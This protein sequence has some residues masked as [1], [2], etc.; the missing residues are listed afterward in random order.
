MTA[1]IAWSIGILFVFTLGYLSIV[2]VPEYDYK[3]IQRLGKYNKIC[4][5]GLNFKIPV[6]D[7]VVGTRTFQIRQLEMK[8]ETKTKDDVFVLISA[9]VQYKIIEGQGYKAFYVLKNPLEQIE[10][11]VFD[12]I[13]AQVPKM[14]LDETFENKDQLADQ[15]EADVQAIMTD[16]YGY[17]IVRALVTD[18]EPD[19]KVKDSMNQINA[20]QRLRVAAEAKGE[21]D[22]ILVV[23]A[24]EAEA[25]SKKLQGKGIADQ[26]KEIIDGLKTS[27]S[28]FQEA[29]KDANAEDVMALVMLTQYLDTLKDI[30]GDGKVVFV[31]SN[32]HG[33]NQF[34]DEIRNTF[35]SSVEATK[36]AAA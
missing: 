19:G 25:Q 31:P 6:L 36:E 24:A 12:T 20:E 7:W 28:D 34:Y 9:A 33:M 11:Y 15:I 1:I 29:I 23:K 16:K 35:M 27:V 30:G 5:A 13:R 2:I 8:V 22:K 3:V 26:R 18:V 10:S 14:A 21:A 32:P 4:T 17:E